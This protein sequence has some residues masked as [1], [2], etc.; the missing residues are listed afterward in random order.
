MKLTSKAILFLYVAVGLA[1]FGH[2]A[3]NTVSCTGIFKNAP[4]CHAIM[5]LTSAAAWP[6]YW[7]WT[8]F[9]AGR[10]ALQ[11]GKE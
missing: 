4:D 11:E 8:Y 5:G 7:S 6:L 3:S 2:A 1:T 9:D 10:A